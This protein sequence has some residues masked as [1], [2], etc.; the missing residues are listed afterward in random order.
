VIPRA[1]RHCRGRRA[2]RQGEEPAKRA[3]ISA[4]YLPH[5]CHCQKSQKNRQSHGGLAFMAAGDGVADVA[6][7]FWVWIRWPTRGQQDV[8]HPNLDQVVEKR[9]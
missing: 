8:K 1:S 7:N 2:L 5:F 3:G 9:F 6:R 4:T